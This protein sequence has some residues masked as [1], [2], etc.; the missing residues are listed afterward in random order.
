MGPIDLTRYRFK[1]A[2]RL[3]LIRESAANKQL[4]IIPPL[5]QVASS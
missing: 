2:L 3:L 1:I 5:F 4:A